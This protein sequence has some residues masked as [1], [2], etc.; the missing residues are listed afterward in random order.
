MSACVTSFTAQFQ[1]ELTTSLADT[2]VAYNASAA[3]ACVNDVNATTCGT[4]IAE[5]QDQTDCQNITQGTVANGGTCAGAQECSSGLCDAISNGVGTCVAAGASGAA[6]AGTG[7]QDGSGCVAGTFPVTTGST[8][9][10]TALFAIGASCG[11]SAQCLSDTCDNTYHCAA[12]PATLDAP[13]CQQLY[14]SF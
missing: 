4:L 3:A 13:T 9:V 12:E 1:T 5:L 10:C 11:S 6:C 2:K 7:I 14:S 8:C